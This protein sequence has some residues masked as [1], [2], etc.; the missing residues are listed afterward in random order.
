MDAIQEFS[1]TKES[2]FRLKHRNFNPSEEEQFSFIFQNAQE[3]MDQ[4]VSAKNILKSMSNQNKELI[5]RYRSLADSIDNIDQLS[6]EGATNL[7]KQHGNEVDF[8]N[9]AI[10]EVGKAKTFIFPPV[11]SSKK[12]KDAWTETTKDMTMKERL[13]AEAPFLAMSFSANVI[14]DHKGTPTGVKEPGSPG[15]TNPFTTPNFSWKSTIEQIQSHYEDF[16]SHYTP[17]QY[18]DVMDLMNRF[19]QNLDRK[20]V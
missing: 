15:Y 6:K 9:D 18:N 11:N 16:K 19:N 1:Q 10:V 20:L 5:Q 7:L 13:L 17:K 3:Q 14:Y 12:V 8:N 2:Q 4:G